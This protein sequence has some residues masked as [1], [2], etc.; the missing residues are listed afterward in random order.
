MEQQGGKEGFWCKMQ[1]NYNSDRVMLDDNANFWSG[2]F[3]EEAI[4]TRVVS[5]R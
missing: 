4:S 3:N 2:H 1:I 5:L